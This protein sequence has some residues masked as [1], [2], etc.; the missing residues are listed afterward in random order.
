MFV[1][2][3][4]YSFISDMPCTFLRLDVVDAGDVKKVVLVV[5]GEIAFH[6]R[7]VHAA[8]GLADVHHRQV[9]AGEDVDG[10][11]ANRQDAAQRDADEGDYHGKGTIQGESDQPHENCS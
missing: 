3:W 11:L 8:V 5:V 6:L 4:K 10:H 7:G 9:Q 1:P 2:G